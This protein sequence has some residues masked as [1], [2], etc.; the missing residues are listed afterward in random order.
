MAEVGL[1]LDGLRCAGCV[2]RVEKSLREAPGV[3]EASVNYAS[4]RA[5]VR[6]AE[7]RTRAEDLVHRVEELG[8]EATPYDPA[9]LERGPQRDA[10][11]ALTRVL[12][13]AFL[14]GNVMMLSLA[15]YIGAAQDLAADTRRLL[16]WTTLALSVPAVVWCALPFW[17][18]AW[19]GLRRGSVTM[20]LPIVLGVGISFV[21]ALAGTLAEADH[22]Y[23]D[24][25]AMIVFLILLSR[26][27][28]SRSRARAAGAVDRLLALTPETALRRKGAALVTVPVADLR[29]GDR[30]VVPTGERIPSDG[31]IVRGDTEVDESLLTGE[32]RPVLRRRGDPVP[33]GAHNVLGEIEIEITAPADRGTLAKL[34]ALLERAQMQRPPIQRLA[35]R[36]AAVFAPSVL[37][38]AGGTALAWWWSGAGWLDTGLTAAAV[39]IVACPCALGLA[40]PTAI[41]AAIGRAA[42]L[43]VLV[44][45]GEALE[46]AAHVDTVLL[47]KTG[48]ASLGRFAVETLAPAPGCE[49]ARLLAAAAAAEGESTHPVA[50]AIRALAQARD[51]AVPRL[52][53]RRTLAGRGVEAGDGE[54]RVLAG[55]RA[56]LR[57]HGVDVPEELEETGE[58][59]AERG[60][61]LAWVARGTRAL[62]VIALSDPPREDAAEAVRRLEALD[63][64]VT[65]LSGDHAAAVARV[66]E[67]AGIARARAGTTPE[68][69]VQA[70]EAA[71]ADGATVLMAGDGLNDAAALAAADVGVAMA[72][73]ADVTLHAADLVIRAPRLG[74][75][76]DAVALSRVTLRRIRENLG[77]ALAYNVVAIPLA[78]TGVLGPL[79]AAVAMS[80]SSLLVTG[81]A[82]R[83]LRW[84]PRR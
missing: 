67:A 69:K 25:A 21:V 29:T 56:L 81:N 9:A 27:L 19:S 38:V 54:Q 47:D 83:L 48:T 78:M 42:R 16:R 46:R 73:G 14:A 3:E 71:R 41:A 44:K 12:V 84:S 49:E 22:L 6:F 17:R 61:S 28:E 2:N 82:A 8:Y 75:L 51:L 32:S 34:A 60:H 64:P 26:L 63:I 23:M 5:L 40:T 7:D 30:V 53:P 68:Q 35:D 20:D 76:V 62:G 79:S 57:E 4:H 24:S 80:L 65:L 55:S 39:L 18:G 70:V 37:L 66:A 45:S 43:G 52:E 50:A 58:K 1:L 77:L 31:R 15:L 13:A 72:R 10:R 59:L 36:V 33:G 74:A 11:A